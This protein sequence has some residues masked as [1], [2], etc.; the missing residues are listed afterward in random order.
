[1]GEGIVGLVAKTGKPVMANDVTKEPRYLATSELQLTKSELAV[2]VR[3]GRQVV[4]VLDIES[5]LL[6]AFDE[7]DLRAAMTL[8]D[9][10]SV[11]LRNAELFEAER[12]RR[13]E[14]AIILEVT[15][16]VNSTLLLDEVLRVAARG[17]ARAV[18]VPNCGMY[19]LDESGTKL[20]PKEGTDSPLSELIRE[21]FM[22]TH[23]DVASDAFLSEVVSTKGPVICANAETDPRTTKEI[24]EKFHLKS[25][26]AVPFVARDQLLG[27]AM[28]TTYEGC[29][30]F[31]PEQV[32][33]AAGIANSVALAIENARL[34]QRTGELAV[35]E[36]RNRLAREIHDTIA[37]GL[38]GI[39]LQLEAA[40]HLMDGNL[41]RA[42][43]RVEKATSLARVSLQ[44]ARRSVWNLRPT[45]LEDRRLAD[46]IRMEIDRLAEEASWQTS[47]EVEGDPSGVS[48]ETENGLF[49]IAQE[50]LNNVRKHA[51]AGHVDV[52]LAFEAG[53]VK[54]RI[55]DD[56]VGFDTATARV[57][58]AEGGF[59]LTSLRE[60]AR[61]L[62]GSIAI[63]SAPGKG[64]TTEVETPFA[65]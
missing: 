52:R 26:L 27:V 41:E 32:E 30:D 8:A 20:I 12:Q 6:N 36:E 19:L 29:Y 10:I 54:L 13:E 4:G 17:M 57:A 58:D 53:R 16:A 62:G 63:E 28:I 5:D 61:L 23:L 34:Y 43:M 51:T 56:G 24:V 14:T 31:K 9:E 64:T 47:F 2:P 44:E 49:R 33:L 50:V 7:A 59:G 22:S 65:R 25:M 1:G 18:G 46:A 21:A 60:R 39:I 45:P 40:E 48:G 55:R 38:T 15:R 42:R 11:A 35:M 37:Q 3:L